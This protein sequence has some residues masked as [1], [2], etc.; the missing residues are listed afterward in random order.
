MEVAQI[1]GLVKEIRRVSDPDKAQII[2]DGIKVGLSDKTNISQFALSD[3][4]GSET[5]PSSAAS[6]SLHEQ[7]LQ[8]G[9]GNHPASPGPGRGGQ[10]DQ[11]PQEGGHQG[12]QGWRGGGCLQTAVRGHA[13]L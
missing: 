3:C 4:S 8:T 12:E 10:P 11:A 5:N 2:W 9:Q 1:T 13:A 7:E 6:V